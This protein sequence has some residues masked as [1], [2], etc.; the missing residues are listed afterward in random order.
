MAFI[1]LLT[2]ILFVLLAYHL[3]ASR[4]DQLLVSPL[5]QK[6]TPARRQGD[7]KDFVP[8][9]PSL[10]F[11]YHFKS[12]AID[13]IIGPIIAV[14]FGWLPAILWI[15]IGVLFMGWVQNYLTTIMAMRK[16]GAS[17]ASLAENLISPR[18]R[19]SLLSFFLIYLILI[20]GA[21]GATM[22]PL[23]ARE[24]VLIG[25]LAIA[26]AGLLVGQLV[27]RWRSGLLL[28]T[29]IPL[30]L[31]FAGIYAG[32]LPWVQSFVR[33]LVSLGG[34]LNNPVI[35]TRPLGFGEV[36][37]S[38]GI[39]TIF[40][41]AFCYLSA[42]L[43][44]WRLAQPVNYLAFWIITLGAIASIAGLLL[45]TFTGNLATTFEIPSFITF[46]QPHLGP[47]WPILFVTISCGAV[48]GWHSL[49]AT[50]STAR[51]IERESHTLPVTAGS[52]LS[53]TILVVLAV[54]FAATL[55]VSSSRYN[56]DLNYALS[57]GPAGVFIHGMTFF[58]NN[59]GIP[60]TLGEPFSAVS[61]ALIA[62]T[63]LQLVLRFLRMSIAELFG[64][65]VSA[66]RNP[67]IGALLSVLV[68]FSLILFGFWQWLWVLFGS[69]N[70]LIAALA[71][72][73]ASIWLAEQGKPYHWV[74][75][76]GKF[77]FATAMAALVYTSIYRGLFLGIL[78]AEEF[79]PGLLVG[80]LITLLFG[81]I[82]MAL[83]AQ[84]YLDARRAL[85]RIKKEAKFQ[86]WVM[87]E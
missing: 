65:Q 44:V 5:R 46:Q 7:G 51:V 76:P 32:S 3:V 6:P 86:V 68:A 29:V 26:M 37:W 58:F 83:A 34:A 1:L 75:W 71:L 27:Y 55:G 67:H 33:N 73:L 31:A 10:A 8:A 15:F 42:V 74:L 14:Q 52:S 36:T 54:I 70:Q 19:I 64:R 41:L 40:I 45:A 78:A 2:T 66:M 62:V 50:F 4:A 59:L 9:F 53:L 12:I 25:F 22:A 39:W 20:I 60:L 63:V 38:M 47:L 79:N 13:P 18:A 23:F 84:L 11:G 57:A 28:A 87:A 69:A 21:F 85:A 43:P 77:L 72:I 16:G 48:S 30:L 80:N 81:I 17:L 82:L 56:P 35:F 24:S 49:V 61:F